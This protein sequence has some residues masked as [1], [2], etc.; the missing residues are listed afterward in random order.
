L[1]LLTIFSLF[2]FM[3]IHCKLSEIGFYLADII[4]DAV[5]YK[6]AWRIHFKD[7]YERC[8]FCF[9]KI[10]YIRIYIYFLINSKFA[11]PSFLRC[12]F[13]MNIIIIL[14]ATPWIFLCMCSSC[15]WIF[16]I[17]HSNFSYWI[18]RRNFQV[19]RTKPS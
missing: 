8:K 15:N 12:I 7:A 17:I 5:F 18:E 9:H 16:R 10:W 6:E 4:Y 13:K 1:Y 2:F 19:R 3:V 11:F 14:I